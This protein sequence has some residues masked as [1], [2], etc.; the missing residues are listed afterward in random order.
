RLPRRRNRE[1]KPV[2]RRLARAKAG[3]REDEQ[4]GHD[5][6][7]GGCPTE[8]DNGLRRGMAA[9]RTQ[10]QPEREPAEYPRPGVEDEQPAQRPR[11]QIRQ[12]AL[13]T[14]AAQELVG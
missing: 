13:V 9:D 4:D 12:L 14:E 7:D 5:R 10:E 3:R 1:E 11:A 6:P 2:H 8:E